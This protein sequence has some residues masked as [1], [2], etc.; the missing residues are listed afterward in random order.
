[1]MEVLNGETMETILYFTILYG[2]QLGLSENRADPK[3]I[4]N[5]NYM[6]YQNCHKWGLIGVYGRQPVHSHTQIYSGIVT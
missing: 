4:A 6:M 1:M 2:F 3:P 5:N